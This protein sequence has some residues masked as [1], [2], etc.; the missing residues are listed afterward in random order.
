MKR[1]PACRPYYKWILYL[2]LCYIPSVTYAQKNSDNQEMIVDQEITLNLNVK[3]VGSSEIEVLIDGNEA[4]LS[5]KELFDFLK[6]KNDISLSTGT[7]SGFFIRQE[8]PY[9]IDK[10]YNLISLQGKVH[11]LKGGDLRQ[12]PT[13]LYLHSA[14][15]GEVFGLVCDFNFRNLTITLTTQLDL[16]VI[17]EQR[18]LLM[19]AN[20]NKLHQEIIADT[21]IN[22]KFHALNIGTADW[23]V[24][25]VQQ[26]GTKAATTM[27]LRL[28]G[29]IAGGETNLS[30]NYNS[31]TALRLRQQNYLWR[32]VNNDNTIFKQAAVG[33]IATSS[34]SSLTAAV[35]GVQ[36][37]NSSTVIR[38]SFGT[39]PLSDYTQPGWTVEL[40]MNNILVDYKQADAAGFFS[41]Q[42]PMIYGAS[43]IQIRCY[44]PWGE[45]DI[46][47]I[48]MNLP[49]N[50]I[51]E[52][53]T[54]YTLSSGILED[55]KHS[56]FSRAELKYGL[57]RRIT[58]SSGM[59]YLSSL[60]ADSFMPFITSS[61][62]V[63]GGLF[64]SGD[65]IF[66]VRTR[67]IVSYN[68]SCFLLE[69]QYIWYKQGQQ[70]MLN[71]YL[72][73]RKLILTKQ[74]KV[75]HV[76]SFSRFSVNQITY[77][78]TK[79]TTADLLLSATWKGMSTNMTTYAFFMNRGYTNIYTNLSFAMPLPYRFVIRPQFQYTY[80]NKTVNSAKMELEKQLTGQGYLNLV[81]DNDFI[82]H[83]LNITLGF[84]FDL[85]FMRVSFSA[86]QTNKRTLFSQSAN[87]GLVYDKQTDYLK[88]N[89][90]TNT[91][92]GGLVISP[93]FDLNSNNRRDENE[94]RIPGLKMSINGGR[95]ETNI[96]DTVTQVLDLE[97]YTSYMLQLDAASFDNIAW[98]LK[99]L[100]YKVIIDP[101]KLTLIEIPVSVA[102]EV[103]GN[104]YLDNIP[105]GTRL[106]VNFYTSNGKLAGHTFTESDGYFSYLGLP[107][108]VYT[109]EIDRQQLKTLNRKTNM[110]SKSFTIKR[111]PEGDVVTGLNFGLIPNTNTDNHRH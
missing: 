49:Y 44:G 28:G 8:N 10:P 13:D 111:I 89:N 94:P 85:S 22:R 19:R 7:V 25:S 50:F 104:I 73:E 101:N 1:F 54:E 55:G 48:K 5:V 2:L 68:T 77:A 17:Q 106:T 12:T 33:K 99:N 98:R 83:T 105:S 51:P 30:L 87:G 59:E 110:P 66:N 34:F 18:L 72:Q 100:T 75:D 26:E 42:V 61:Y 37:T 70:A 71:N 20:M 64:L 84:R 6:I 3:G 102:G 58:V 97:P 53:E 82:Y 65:Y 16:P 81:A 60:K 93:Y 40:Y 35:V 45:E 79:Q 41:F 69:G 39:Y 46:R 107:P 32:Y 80:R 24:T 74:F 11:Q 92:R 62:R 56:N 31:N 14:V 38:K 67:G 95:M 21:T 9:V 27:N 78:A 109:A 43:S 86:R 36:I 52:N 47:D 15:F 57:N 29:I 91:G 76:S 4:Y 23:A 96:R 63:G 103:S 88:L 108:G 90:R